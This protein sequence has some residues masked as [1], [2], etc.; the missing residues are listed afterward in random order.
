VI[1]GFFGDVDRT[2]CGADFWAKIY[3]FKPVHTHAHLTINALSM[4]P[5]TIKHV[6]EMVAG[7][8]RPEFGI[9]VINH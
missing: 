6:V 7:H 2:G 9:A 3:L 8:E 5:R 4:C 1:A